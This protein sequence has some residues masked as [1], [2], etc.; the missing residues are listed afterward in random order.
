ML[1]QG[2][3]TVRASRTST[4]AAQYV[5]MSTEHQQYSL[6]NQSDAIAKYAET[7]GMEIVRSYSDAA[8]SGLS[9]EDRHALRRLIND[10][11]TGNA[12]FAAVLVYDVSR[13]GRFQDSDESAHYEYICKR[14]N[15][16]VHYC[17]EPF[18]NDGSLPSS[19]LKA[20]KRM[21]AA[22]YSRELSAKVFAGKRRLIELGFRQGGTA[23]YGLRRLLL[24]ALG[25]RKRIL[26]FGQRK[27]LI[28]DR[29]VLTPGPQ[30]EINVVHEIYDRFINGMDT[31]AGIARE[32]NRRGVPS[33]FGRPW[34]RSM[35]HTILT[36]PKY[37]GVSEFNRTSK[38]LNGKVVRN[39]P[40]AWIRRE[41]AFV[42]IVDAGSFR[43]AQEIIARRNH[44]TSHDEVLAGLRELLERKGRLASGLIDEGRSLASRYK[45][46]S[47]FGGL[48]AA[49]ELVGYK[50]S[51]NYSF[52]RT[53]RGLDL[54]KRQEVLKLVTE[55]ESVGA[56][57]RCDSEEGL[58]TVNE[59][60]TIAFSLL[61]C[62]H[63]K[64]RGLRWILRVSARADITVAARMTS[65]NNSVLDY[66]A[67]P[68]FA[69]QAPSVELAPTN[70][71]VLDAHRF[72]TLEIVKSL[73]RRRAVEVRHEAKNRSE[74]PDQ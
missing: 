26:T 58:L 25:A 42:P 21:M 48:L 66:Y 73:A 24:D 22:E 32:L 51:H 3:T 7:H 10:V 45:I 8:K 60:F 19:L 52:L 56:S 61:R 46:N 37:L 38:K 31:F 47:R 54:L 53:N 33:E 34:T 50:P 1:Y 62:R 65:E 30:N 44:Y 43:A 63:T 12:D 69:L 20:I 4:R 74:D 17:A 27:S 35:V 68:R 6:Q 55:L 67:V 36:N 72:D 49:Y 39:S 5:R 59:E 16:T 64:Y 29:V 13:W 40:D 57:V 23:G 15:V 18:V 71:V 41:Q 70:S 2:L 11:E 14:A 28:T 9:I